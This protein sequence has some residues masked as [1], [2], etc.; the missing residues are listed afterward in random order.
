MAL[1]PLVPRSCPVC[2]EPGQRLLL[3][4]PLAPI[5]GVS[6]H[7]GYRVVACTGCGMVYADGLP[8]QEAFDHYYEACSRY[9]DPTRHGLPSPVDQARF[10]AI[11]GELATQL[12]DR[13]LAIAE[14]GSS[15]GG[16]LAE[17]GKLGF[18]RLLGVDPSAQCGRSAQDNQGVRVAQGTIFQAIDGGP[19]DLIIA[20]GVV[21]HI[22]ALDAALGNL[23]RSLA[24]GGLLYVEVPDLEGFHRTN[25]APF[26]EF[27]LEHI[28]FFTRQSLD[29]LMGRF[30]FQPAFGHVV[31]R[32]HGGGSSMQVL[33]FA[34]RQGPRPESF[35]PVVDASGPAAA[36]AYAAQGERQAA[37]EGVLLE[38][39]VKDGRPF[40]LWGAGTLTCRLLATTALR[41]AP[42]AAL[43]DSNPHLQGRS[44]H[45]LAIQ[46]PAWLRGFHGP[47]LVAS[48]GYAADILRTLRED[49]RLDNEVLTLR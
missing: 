43:V 39:L 16:L 48:Y 25:E 19:H 15:T 29:N 42:I 23:A 3:D 46:P 41:A 30:G 36:L 4:H 33:A 9:E 7:A 21:E 40:A 47:V 17:L 6:L 2:D 11:A 28:N 12:P 20:V 5:D 44:L 31:D 37:E 8:D 38:R 35:Q 14:I 10:H 1:A 34:Y 45:G 13:A 49:L 22:R 26:Q 27:S 32:L 24:P 18:T